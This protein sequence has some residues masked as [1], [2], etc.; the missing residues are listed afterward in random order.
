VKKHGPP[1]LITQGKSFPFIV[2]SPQCPANQW[3][4]ADDLLAL[5]DDIIH[6]Y[7]VDT[8]RIY[9]TGLSMGGFG[10]WTLGVTYPDRLAALVPICGWGEPF[11][12]SRLKDMP[13]W[14]FHGA[15]DPLVP[16]TKGKE[17]IDAV[18]H[19]GGSPKFT[20]YPEAEHDSWTETYDNPELYSWLLHQH[21]GRR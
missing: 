12:A 14:A 9:V 21:K 20:I 8:D 5:L 19:A 15:R 2:A 18:R 7:A 13:I 11:A 6:S 17:M 4:K 3:W 10:T 1:K 16:L